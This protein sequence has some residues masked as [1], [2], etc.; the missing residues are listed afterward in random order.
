MG[1]LGHNR[2]VGKGLVP[3]STDMVTGE[4]VVNEEDGIPYFKKGDNS[5]IPIGGG[6]QEDYTM[7]IGN[8]NNPLLDLPLNNNLAMKQG[9][10]SVTFTR[11]TTA[12]YVDRYGVVQTAGVDEARFEKDGLLVEGASTNKLLYSGDFTNSAW[13]KETA[14]AVESA[15]L[16]PDGVSKAYDISNSSSNNDV[17]KQAVSASPSLE[18]V[19][20]FF[21]KGVAG[22]IIYINLKRDYDSGNGGEFIE[23]ITPITMNGEWQRASGKITLL[24]DNTGVDCRVYSD[25]ASNVFQI[26]GAQ[27][28]QLPFASSYIPT[29]GV[30][31]TR[32]VDNC[33]LDINGNINNIG[34]SMTI[35]CDVDFDV[36][37]NT[38]SEFL[39]YY[40]NDDNSITFRYYAGKYEVSI[41]GVNTQF[42]T[43]NQ[44]ESRVA[45]TYGGTITRLY[46]DGSIIVERSAIVPTRGYASG[47]KLMIGGLYTTGDNIQ[48]LSGNIKNLRIYDKALTASEIRL[49]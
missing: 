23:T 41:N 38:P 13:V 44:G 42:I 34:D 49:A 12:T 1:K 36:N 7:T 43:P 31:V 16:S 8:I 45:M 33:L 14:T 32:T 28:E 5:V 15:E 18:H 22:T 30:A 29:T 40:N 24:A 20:S 27:L 11:A 47:K 17:V 48:P 2:I 35:I 39:S 19:Y 9:S 46:I 3:K 6:T 37:G 4:I 21:V 10:G 25:S 26:W